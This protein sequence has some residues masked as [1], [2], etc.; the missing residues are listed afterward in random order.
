[1]RLNHPE[2]ILP[3]PARSAEKLSSV[4]QAPG[5]KKGWGTADLEDSREM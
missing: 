5:D 1:M 3:S 2:T 4:K